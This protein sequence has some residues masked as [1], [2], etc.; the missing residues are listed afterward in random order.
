MIDAL[1]QLSIRIF[2]YLEVLHASLHKMLIFSE[3]FLH[4]LSSEINLLIVMGTKY[5]YIGDSKF[6]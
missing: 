4:I 5:S 1:A 6:L 2:T 3:S